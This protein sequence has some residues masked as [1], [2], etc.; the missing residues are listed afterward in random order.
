MNVLK[1]SAGK[2]PIAGHDAGCGAVVD[3]SEVWKTYGDVT[4]LRGVS[5]TMDPGTIT[6]LVGLNGAGKSTLISLIVGLQRPDR[7]RVQVGGLNPAEWGVAARK[8]V[9]FAP[10][11]LAVYMGLTVRQNLDFYCDI[12]RYRGQ[13]R[14]RALDRAIEGLFLG[15]LLRR[16][17]ALLSG[18]EKRRLH[19]A[20]ALLAEAPL[21]VLDEPTVGADLA[22]RTRLLGVVKDRS[23]EGSTIIYATHYLSEIE[24]LDGQIL[25]IDKGCIKASGR[26]DEILRK[27]GQARVSLVFRTEPPPCLRQIGGVST[28][29]SIEVSAQDRS[30]DLLPFVLSLLSHEEMLQITGITFH[31]PTLDDIFAKLIGAEEADYHSE[32]GESYE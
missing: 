26:V 17:V 14:R 19:T 25:V 32:A 12:F 11:E 18:G 20:M 22:S 3:V 31:P 21:L 9:G 5:C 24:H 6:S 23:A 15:A 10:Q 4:A 28:G 27:Y 7:G 13:Y 16:K 30:K 8:L 29:N 1:Q 2:L